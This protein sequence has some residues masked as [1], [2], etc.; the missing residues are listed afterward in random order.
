MAE[1]RKWERDI[2]R[3]LE[4]YPFLRLITK[5]AY[6][7]IVYFYFRKPNFKFEIHKNASIVTPYQWAN[8]PEDEK[9]SFFGYY[10]KSPWSSNMR[11]AILN[12]REKDYLKV[13]VFDQKKKRLI[14]VGKSLTWNWQQGCMSQWLPSSYKKIIVY[15]CSEKDKLGCRIKELGG[16]LD[17][18]IEYPIQSLNP[19]KFEALALNYRLLW[20]LRPE[21]GYNVNSINFS[22]NQSIDKDGIWR[23]NLDTGCADLIISLARLSE[24]NPCKSMVGAAHKVNH[25]LYSPSGKHFIFLHRFYNKKRKYSRLYSANTDGNELTLLMDDHMVSHYHWRDDENIIVWGRKRQFGDHYYL[26]NVKNAKSKIIG[27]NILDIYD[28]GHC[29]FSPNCRWI[30]TDTYPDRGRMQLLILFDTKENKFLILGSFFSP[31]QFSGAKRCDLHPRWSPDGK[32]ISIDSAH[33]GIRRAY[34]LNVEQL[35]E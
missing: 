7:R 5:E 8:L 29:T 6:K 35:V 10:D 3:A 12:L 27:E 26:V 4:R 30:L 33:E 21:Y 19:R 15:N 1:F 22:K 13:V 32:W 17:R 14:Q 34:F 23:V 20:K 16:E 24:T 25:L 2:A 18:F 28:D 9:E 31:P 11:F